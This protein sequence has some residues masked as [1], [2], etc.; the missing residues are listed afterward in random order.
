MRFND[1]L[2]LIA[3]GRRMGNLRHPVSSL[4]PRCRSASPAPPFDVGLYYMEFTEGVTR[5][6]QT[7]QVVSLPLY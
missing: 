7:C 3:L 5:R 6:A 1:L 2:H 4:Q